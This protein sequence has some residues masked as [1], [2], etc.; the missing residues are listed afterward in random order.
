VARRA[1][2]QAGVDWKDFGD[3]TFATSY[4]VPIRL[5]DEESCDEAVRRAAAG[6]DR[7][8]PGLREKIAKEKLKRL[9]AEERKALDLPAEKRS[10]AQN[11]LAMEAQLRLIV[12][13]DEVARRVQG[14]APRREALK[15]A[16]EAR[17]QQEMAD[18]IRRERSK[19]NFNYWRTRAAMEQTPE[20]LATRVTVYKA[21]QAFAAGDI[22]TAKSLYEEGI[23]G[24]RLL[25]DRF[26]DLKEDVTMGE[27]V[28]E[29]IRR[30]EKCLKQLDEKL[31]KPFLLQD[32]LDKY[33]SRFGAPEK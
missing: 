23:K 27:N 25:L 6:I 24:W 11:Q 32:M 29:T 10:N 18:I 3:R 21:G 31:P 2:V 14:A 17:Q 28:V 4:E 26:P 1:W 12:T 7:I 13:H 16:D 15:L 20:A 19:V 8:E 30:Y 22:S 33:Q 5:N 9:T